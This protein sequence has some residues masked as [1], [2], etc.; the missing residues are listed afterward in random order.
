MLTIHSEIKYV[1]ISVFIIE[2]IINTQNVCF[3]KKIWVHY[4][5]K[6][7]DNIAAENV[8]YTMCATLIKKELSPMKK[9]NEK[10]EKHYN[11]EAHI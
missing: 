8:C 9:K 3:L 4:F 6:Q 5:S 7:H 10:K 1:Y 2:K 11:N